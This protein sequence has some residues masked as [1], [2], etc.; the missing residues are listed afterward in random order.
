MDHRSGMDY[1]SGM[2]HRP[3]SGWSWSRDRRKD[4]M[5][6]GQR[7]GEESWQSDSPPEDRY[8]VSQQVNKQPNNKLRDLETDWRT[9]LGQWN[10]P[11]L[12]MMIAE[13]IPDMVAIIWQREF[14]ELA[15]SD[16]SL[17]FPPRRGQADEDAV[18]A[19]K[20]LLHVI[21]NRTRITTAAMLLALYFVHRYRLFPSTEVGC[22]G[23]QYRMFLVGMLL[24][25]KYS[26]DHPFSN[27]VWA[28]LSELPISHINTM[29]RD[30]LQRIEHRLLVQFD[31]F[32]EWVVALDRRFGW[33]GAILMKTNYRNMP[34]PPTPPLLSIPAPVRKKDSKQKQPASQLQGPLQT[35]TSGRRASHIFSL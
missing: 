32:Q 14:I 24:A 5:I 15:Q 31:E 35:T 6:E 4:E 22:A 20:K 34:L 28:Q 30:F 21:L 7:S 33:T 1:Q 18:R 23:S 16:V 27:R 13:C 9:F 26:E 12:R 10:Q 19:T 11:M 25:H 17:G 2:G 8:R 3:Y 29:E